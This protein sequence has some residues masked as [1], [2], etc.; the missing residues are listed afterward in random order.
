V[1]ADGQFDECSLTLRELTLIRES[2]V[3]TLMNAYHQ[4]ISYP[5]FNPPSQ[6]EKEMAKADMTVPPVI[7]SSAP[8]SKSATT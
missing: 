2:L 8:A 5:G 3:Q 6:T 1:A 4:R 7:P